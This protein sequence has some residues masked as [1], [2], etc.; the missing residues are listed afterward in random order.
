[1]HIRAFSQGGIL[2]LN[3]IPA[4]LTEDLNTSLISRVPA[5]L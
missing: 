2:E 1:M 3:V 4:T 5:F